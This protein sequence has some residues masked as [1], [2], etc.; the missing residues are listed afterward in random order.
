MGK[1]AILC[2]PD[3]VEAIAK[4]LN[5]PY[6]VGE[7]EKDRVYLAIYN[8]DCVCSA[9]IFTCT[10][11]MQMI[12]GINPD[13]FDRCYMAQELLSGVCKLPQPITLRKITELE[14]HCAVV[15]DVFWYGKAKERV[16]LHKSNN[17]F[18]A[19]QQYPIGTEQKILFLKN[20]QEYWVD[21]S[22]PLE[23]DPLLFTNLIRNVRQWDFIEN[24][25]ESEL[26]F[27]KQASTLWVTS[28]N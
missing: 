23:L 17:W 27:Q 11:T 14:R 26:L 5:L 4:M 20:D 9:E 13:K 3:E 24:M 25:V 2:N 12:Q 7:I 6:K 19:V 18:K 10:S 28:N 8:I 15:P 22:K 21:D 16:I 1:I